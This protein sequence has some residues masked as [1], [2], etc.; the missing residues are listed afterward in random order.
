MAAAWVWAGTRQPEIGCQEGKAE[1]RPAA[2]GA[3]GAA[4]WAHRLGVELAHTQQV[5]VW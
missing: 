4:E 2:A 3:A 1:V 5:V